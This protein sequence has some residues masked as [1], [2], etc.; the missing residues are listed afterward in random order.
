MRF[1]SSTSWPWHNSVIGLMRLLEGGVRVSAPE[2]EVHV[3]D[4]DRDTGFGRE[5]TGST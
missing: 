1:E 3:L 5:N 2:L 4:R